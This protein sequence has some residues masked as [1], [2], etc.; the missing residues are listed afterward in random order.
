[1]T[2]TGLYF[3][4]GSVRAIGVL[5]DE[6]DF[7]LLGN[8]KEVQNAVVVT[9]IGFLKCNLKIFIKFVQT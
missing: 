2:P 5:L 7:F 4:V 8:L 3:G 1:L 9:I 6:D